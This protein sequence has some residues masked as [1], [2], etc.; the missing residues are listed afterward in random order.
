M[1]D[2][3]PFNVL[4]AWLKQHNAAQLPRDASFQLCVSRVPGFA[5][6]LSTPVRVVFDLFRDNDQQLKLQLLADSEARCGAGSV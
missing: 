5:V 6:R 4:V 3:T 1:K 2:S